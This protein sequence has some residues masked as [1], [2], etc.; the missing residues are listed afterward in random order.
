M[1]TVLLLTTFLCFGY[2]SQ[3]QNTIT[4]RDSVGVK[5]VNGPAVAADWKQDTAMAWY[6]KSYAA[7]KPN[8]AY[9]EALQQKGKDYRFVV[10]GGTWC[11]DTHFLLP[12]FFAW[13]D[14]AGFDPKKV[15]LYGVDRSKKSIG[16]LTQDWKI[17]N[18]PTFILLKGDVEVYRMVEYGKYAQPD[19]ELAEQLK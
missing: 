7:Y 14:A 1:K 11:E 17:I 16:T 2:F 4:F 8:A 12:K 6:A 18:V 3:A 9:V 13:L 19:K 10:F 5:I 15:S